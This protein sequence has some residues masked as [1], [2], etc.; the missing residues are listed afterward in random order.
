MRRVIYFL[1]RALRNMRQ[2]PFL[3]SAAISTVTVALVILAFFALIVINVQQLTRHWSRDVQVVAYFDHPPASPVLDRQL[4]R[5][6]QYPEVESVA[7]ISPRQA[8]KRFQVRLGDD[9]DLLQG[10]AND[11][12]PAALEVRLTEKYR[13][14]A[15]V[16]RVVERLRR[17]KSFA[18]LRYGQEWL[19]RFEAFLGLLRTAGLVLG[20]FLLFA[21]LFIV[22]NTIKL[23]LYARREELEVMAL[24][25]GT[26]AFIKA[27][28]LLEGAL[29]GALGGL[30][31]L[32]TSFLFF[33]MVLKEDLGRLLLASGLGKISFL[34]PHWQILIVLLGCL[35]GLFGSLF[36]LRKFVRI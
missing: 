17:N 12:L 8:F 25:G 35:L 2:S 6:R 28:F 21:A 30:F 23:T 7:Y 14:S 5:I 4:S 36:S 13:N 18:D 29:Q 11:F 3:C 26:P 10:M 27:P 24:V 34:P 15:G 32:L 20:G 31:A 1:L 33:S 16:Q 9:A 22:S 19:E